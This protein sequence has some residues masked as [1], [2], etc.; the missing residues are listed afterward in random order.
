M[1]ETTINGVNG[2]I[3]RSQTAGCSQLLMLENFMPEQCY[4]VKNIPTK[5]PLQDITHVRHNVSM[6]PSLAWLP[7]VHFI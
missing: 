4:F 3:P 5:R 7:F 2:S 6:P 1:L